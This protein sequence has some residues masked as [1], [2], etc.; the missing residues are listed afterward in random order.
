MY[1]PATIVILRHI[2]GLFTNTFSCPF[3]YFSYFSHKVWHENESF[4]KYYVNLVYMESW[5]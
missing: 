4:T 3:K 5:I 1:Q 2:G